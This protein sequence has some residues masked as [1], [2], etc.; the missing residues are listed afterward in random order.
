MRA[1]LLFPHQVYSSGNEGLINESHN[2]KVSVISDR[3]EHK[4]ISYLYSPI[5]TLT[6]TLPSHQ[7]PLILP[8]SIGDHQHHPDLPNSIMASDTI[9]MGQYLFQRIK[10]LGAEH[11]LGVPGD[12]N[13]RS[14]RL[15]CSDQDSSD[16][17]LQSPC[18]MKSTTF[19]VSSGSAAVTSSME[20]M[21]L[22]GTRA[23]R[24]HQPCS[25]R[26]MPWAS[27]PR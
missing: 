14:C 10:Q 3:S 5:S 11:I 4:L 25:L 24:G 9:C 2:L 19:P 26:L 27:C 23:L 8:S 1:L 6:L 7:R 17:E 21:L 20:H 16:I 12:F 18:W 13:R 22:M 15:F